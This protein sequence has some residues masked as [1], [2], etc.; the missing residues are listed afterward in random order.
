VWRSNENLDR[1]GAGKGLLLHDDRNFVS[2]LQPWKTARGDNDISPLA[3]RWESANLVRVIYEFIQIQSEFLEGHWYND[4][5]VD[6]VVISGFFLDVC[7]D[8]EG[9]IHSLYPDL[10]NR[11]RRLRGLILD[12]G[13]R[14]NWVSALSINANQD[15]RYA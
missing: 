3:G 6:P 1:V 4:F 15:Q 13:F 8:R 7:R 10:R 2:W 14:V 11:R 12:F 9:S 5:D